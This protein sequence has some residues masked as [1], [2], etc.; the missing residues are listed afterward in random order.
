MIIRATIWT[1]ADTTEAP[2]VDETVERVVVAVLEEKGH[3]QALKQVRFQNFPRSTMGHPGD[4]IRELF[5]TENSI[6]LDWE[7]LHSD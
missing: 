7:L 4:N 6:E 5:L 3:D 2:G 1:R